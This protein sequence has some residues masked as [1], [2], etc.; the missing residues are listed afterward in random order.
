MRLI[1]IIEKYGIETCKYPLEPYIVPDD[2]RGKPEYNHKLCIGCAA[3]GVACPP[4]AIN[5]KANNEGE[6]IWEFNCGR[7]IFCG[8]C[9]EV[10]PTNAIKLSH[11]Y[12]MAAKFDKSAL[13][14]RGVIKMAKCKDCGNFFASQ[15]L[16]DYALKRLELSNLSKDRFE[17]A[18]FYVNLCPACKSKRAIAN[19][20]EIV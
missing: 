13:I 20:K 1:D 19:I 9:E 5:V 16:I 7:C 12:E 17:N 6:I 4:N 2:F 14:Q 10:C 3:C 15:R 8:R 11:E 18:K